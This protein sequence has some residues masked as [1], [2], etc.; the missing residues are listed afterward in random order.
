MMR[1][2]GI[3]GIGNFQVGLS[4]QQAAELL[5][6]RW[7]AALR[8]GLDPNGV[9]DL[10]VTYYAHCLTRDEPQA[11][12]SLDY[13]SPAAGQ[14]VMAW[15]AALGAPPEVA[16][17]RLMAPVRQAADWIAGK[18]KLD[19]RS[20][21][22]LVAR[23]AAEVD[24]YLNLPDRREAA[25]AMVAAQ[26]AEYSPRIVI[27]HSLG[28]V[29]AY[30]ALFDRPITPVDLLVTLGSP[31]GMPGVIFE[32]L[33]PAPVD[34]L[35]A[36]PPGAT[37]WVNIADPG[38]F[39]AVPRRLHRLFQGISSDLEASIGVLQFHKATAYLASPAVSG[40]LAA[41]LDPAR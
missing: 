15:V 24:R 26:L 40:L 10:H 9:I 21:R 25:R 8:P 32:K 33:K 23:F 18:Y 5:S 14:L 29:V 39:V 38:D 13:L 20:V 36:K 28:S 35:G 27:A 41:Y 22:T 30:E 4:P 6:Q 7:R 12:D 11:P 37:R 17:G 34:G 3:H 16:Q 31:L 2:L 1:I 19:R